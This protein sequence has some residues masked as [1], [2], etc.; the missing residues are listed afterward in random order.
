MNITKLSQT[1][2]K[3]SITYQQTL[4]ALLN[5]ECCVGVYD[6]ETKMWRAGIYLNH[7]HQTQR[8]MIRYISRDDKVLINNFPVSYVVTRKELINMGYLPQENIDA[9]V[10]RQTH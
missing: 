7:W 6:F 2:T 3:Y 4:D 8:I 1:T 10:K 5:A 9:W